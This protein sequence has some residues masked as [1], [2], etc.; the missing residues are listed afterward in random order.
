MLTQP[1]DT[2]LTDEAPVM[3]PV[4]KHLTKASLYSLRPRPCE[5]DA[6]VYILKH[7]GPFMQGCNTIY[8]L[9]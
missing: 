1:V 4:T 2:N 3:M 7:A 8:C 5:T 6:G 9:Q